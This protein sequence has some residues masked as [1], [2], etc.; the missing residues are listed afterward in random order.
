MYGDNYR[1]FFESALNALTK[2]D[3]KLF[4]SYFDPQAVWVYYGDHPTPVTYNGLEAIEEGYRFYETC[5]L[6]PPSYHL[7]HL[8]VE[9]D[10]AIAVLYDEGVRLDG[11]NVHI[12]YVLYF[13]LNGAGDKIQTV[14]NF[15]DTHKLSELWKIGQK[16]KSQPVR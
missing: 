9:N 8:V 2:R 14:H 15:G 7:R 4:L 6:S 5:F 12:E 13:Q 1:K 11:K 16:Y 10:K 3:L